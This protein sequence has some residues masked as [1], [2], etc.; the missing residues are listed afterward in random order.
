MKL[1]KPQKEEATRTSSDLQIKHSGKALDDSHDI[2]VSNFDKYLQLEK[3]DPDR[4][5]VIRHKKSSASKY[6]FG[7]PSPM[8]VLYENELPLHD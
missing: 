5:S 8:Q 6:S 4:R 3:A 7:R 1:D 2:T